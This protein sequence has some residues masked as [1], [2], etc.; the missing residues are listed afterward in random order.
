MMNEEEECGSSNFNNNNN[1]GFS[2]EKESG[3]IWWY[4]VS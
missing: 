4:E 2:T 1:E 3:R